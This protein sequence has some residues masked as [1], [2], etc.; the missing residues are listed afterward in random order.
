MRPSPLLPACLPSASEISAPDGWLPLSITRQIDAWLLL[1]PLSRTR[2]NTK[3][4]YKGVYGQPDGKFEAY[5]TLPKSKSGSG[6]GTQKNLG[7]Y[8]TAEEAALVHAK[9]YIQ[10]LSPS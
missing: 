7:R 9:A 3:S 1:S 10:V 8:G 6:R 4:G 5:I 2:S